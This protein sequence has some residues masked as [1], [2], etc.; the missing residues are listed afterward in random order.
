MNIV[1]LGPDC[2]GKSTYAKHL[3]ERYENASLIKNLKLLPMNYDKEFIRDEAVMHM[4]HL[5]STCRQHLGRLIILDRMQIP[6]DIIY[7]PIFE[8][9]KSKLKGLETNLFNIVK[10]EENVHHIKTLFVFLNP[11]T[12]VLEAR[13]KIRG[14]D[15]TDNF[16]DVI[17]AKEKYEEWYEKFESKL[18]TCVMV[19][20]HEG[21]AE[22]MKIIDT[23]LVTENKYKNILKNKGVDENEK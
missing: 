4:H 10:Y 21:L 17:E 19:K 8:N 9:K 5:M 14:D 23:L 7:T 2:S 18:F 16:I 15:H 22:V 11:D 12:T 20:D 6:D 13:F 3:M 1:L